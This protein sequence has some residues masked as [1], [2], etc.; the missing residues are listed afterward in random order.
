MRQVE[1]PNEDYS[2]VDLIIDYVENPREVL[3]AANEL[4]KQYGIEFVEHQT[5]IS[6]HAF[7]LKK[8]EIKNPNIL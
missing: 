6:S 4:L 7:S 3:D 8:I 5:N 2:N 1:D